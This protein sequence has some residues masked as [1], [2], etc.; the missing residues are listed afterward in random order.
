MKTFKQGGVHPLEM[1]SLSADEKIEE[2]KTP[3]LIT[4]PVSQ[5][6]G[7]PAKPVVNTGDRVLKG[8]VV[9]VANGHVSVPVHSPVC[10]KILE[11]KNCLTSLCKMC[12]HI[13]IENDGGDEWYE[14]L[15]V[16]RDWHSLDNETILSAIR[17]AGIVG[18]GGA[19][20][21]THVKLMPPK[22]AKIDTLI[23]NGVECEPYLTIDYRMMLERHL[24]IAEGIRIL[25]KV[26]G[27]KRAIVGIEANKRA[28]F[29][30]MKAAL[31]E[32]EDI[33][34][35]ILVVK[36]PQGSEKQ[37]IDVLLDRQV[38]PGKL[39]LDVGVVVQNVTTTYAVYEAVVFN[40]PLINR[41]LTV[42]GNG[43]E[44]SA[45]LIV[46]IGTPIGE[47][48]KNQGLK[49]K[50]KKIILGGPM[51]GLSVY[52]LNLPVIKGTSGILA[53]ENVLDVEAGPCI[54][55]GNCIRHC[56]VSLVPTEIRAAAHI[57]DAEQ[58]E[59]LNVM[60]CMECGSCAFQCPARIPLVHYMKLAK[61]EL[62]AWKAKHRK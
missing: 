45:N 13:V 47:V 59:Q 9:A 4:L 32:D 44:K 3:S 15:N 33:D 57:G 12:Q 10:G 24:E 56:P 37:L 62:A 2:F 22:E 26:L 19:A 54:R 34:V 53:L 52:D 21:P 48:I 35:E 17:D 39:P 14:G 41:P 49:D 36:Y 27:V 51:T 29:A 6:I 11:V 42:T 20:F 38:P 43:I 25:K 30:S 58:Y 60:V 61:A 40:R 7:A 16:K 55:C 23:I 1:K 50:V 46:P 8:Q 31:R 28:A 18:M 5:H